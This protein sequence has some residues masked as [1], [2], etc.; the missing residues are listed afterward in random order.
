M[1]GETLAL[2]GRLAMGRDAVVACLLAS[3][4][5]PRCG[6]DDKA[7]EAKVESHLFEEASVCNA[8]SLSGPIHPRLDLARLSHSAWNLLGHVKRLVI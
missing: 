7:P 2:V 1:R 3:T 6:N 5:L 8:A 4:L